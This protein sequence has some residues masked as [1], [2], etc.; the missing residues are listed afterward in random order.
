[1]DNKVYAVRCT[2]Y[3]QADEKLGLLLDMMGGM[4]RFAR[5]G[6]TL[7]LKANLLESI[8][9]DR[10]VTTTRRWWQRW[11]PRRRK[12]GQRRSFWTAQAAATGRTAPPPWRSSTTSPAWRRPP[13]SPVQSSTT[14]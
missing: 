1:M 3:A 10:A 11:R 4:G 2:D 6:E 12:R 9:P 5:E 13:G 8:A 14:T 7:A